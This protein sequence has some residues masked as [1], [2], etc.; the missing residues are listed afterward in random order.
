[1]YGMTAQTCGFWLKIK[2][3]TLK[4]TKAFHRRRGPDKGYEPNRATL[5][6]CGIRQT[7]APATLALACSRSRSRLMKG[8]LEA[9]DWCVALCTGVL[10][11][12]LCIG[13]YC[14]CRLEGRLY[15]RPPPSGHRGHS[16]NGDSPGHRSR[17]SPARPKGSKGSS[18]GGKGKSDCIG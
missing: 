8:A 15:W 3:S 4:R 16:G 1:M 12:A 18:Q 9:E 14:C 13:I 10:A 5:G 6:G 11:L 7:H 17:G 2:R